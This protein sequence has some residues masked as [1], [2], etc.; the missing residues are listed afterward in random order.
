MKYKRI[1]RV[2]L[3]FLLFALLA[4][5]LAFGLNALV[6]HKTKDRMI[7]PEEAAQLTGIDCIL[8]LGCGVRGDTPSPM[9]ADR[10][11]QGIALYQAGIAPKLLMSGDHGRTEYDEVNVMK[12]YAMDAGIPSEDIFM[13]HAGF[14][15]YESLYRARDIFCAKRMVVVSQQY[16]LYRAVYDGLGLGL[17]VW[18]VAAQDMNYHGQWYREVR[19]L[20][21]RDK[22]VIWLLMK[23]PPKYL[24]DAIPVSGDGNFTNDAFSQ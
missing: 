20:I 10:L 23:M 12:R 7:S 4:I 21:A 22:D 6:L 18:G 11:D 17:E 5:I 2:I 13:D 24:G 3:V 8:I 14:S 15:T 1:R 19:E 16:H 9:L